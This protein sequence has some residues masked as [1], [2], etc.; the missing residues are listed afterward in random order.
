[1]N[2]SEPNTTEQPPP[3]PDS[4]GRSSGLAPEGWLDKLKA[5]VGLRGS[6]TIR[7]EIV[8][9]LATGAE[10]AGFSLE[11]RAMLTNILSLREVRVDD[12]M[13]PRADID[14]VEIGTSLGGLLAAFQKSGHSRMPVHRETLDDPVL[15]TT[16]SDFR[17]YRRHG[18]QTV[19]GVM[20]A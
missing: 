1:M 12:I 5:A 20:P 4:P 9:A 18:R 16:D 10:D 13:V 2:M 11:E 14:A 6:S 19:P 7:Q 8:D 17:V 15:L 3:E